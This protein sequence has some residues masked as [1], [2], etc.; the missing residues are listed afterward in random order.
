MER[1][2]ILFDTPERDLLYP[3]THTR[4]VAACRVGILTIQEKWEHWLGTGVSHYTVPHLQEKFPL[5]R[6]EDTTVNVLISGHILPDAELVAA[7]MALRP[8]EELYKDN[9]LVAKV[10]Q[11]KEVH[12]LPAASR[13]SYTGPVT[14]IFRPWDIFLQNDRAIREDFVMLTKGRT[15]APLP[16]GIQVSNPEQVFLEPGAQVY[17]SILNAATGPIYIGRNALV[18]EGSMVRGPLAMG[19]GAVLKMG[20]KV[21]GATTLG[22]Y[23]IGGGEIKNSVFFGYSNKSHDGYVGD[24]VIGEWCNLGGNTTCSNVKNNAGVVKVWMESKQSAEPA[25]QKCGVMMGDYS[26]CA[27]NTMM[28]TG[29][30]VGVSCN[31]FGA[32]FPPV[33]LPSFTWGHQVGTAAYRLPEALRDAAAWMGFKG[34]Q[35]EDADRRILEAV[36]RE[37]NTQRP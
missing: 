10:A 23:C 19:E 31:I 27:I 26:R 4:P 25:G 8:E 32:G 13:K 11:G 1:H 34:R 24:A 22:P 28:N 5:R 37:T 16:E 7:I 15:S 29:T 2:Y 12:L 30:V 35:L 36:F 20:A 9:H 18:M 17:S 33:F 3:F 6:G 21:Y 14:G